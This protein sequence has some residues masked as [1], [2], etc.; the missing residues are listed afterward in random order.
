MF[1]QFKALVW[2]RGWACIRLGIQPGSPFYRPPN[3]EKKKKNQFTHVT[4]ECHK[5]KENCSI[6]KSL[7]SHTGHWCCWHCCCYC[8]LISMSVNQISSTQSTCAPS[9]LIPE[10]SSRQSTITTYSMLWG[11]CCC[12]FFQ[13]S[14]FPIAIKHASNT[15]HPFSD[16]NRNRYPT[17]HTKS[18][19][20]ISIKIT[21]FNRN[22]NN[23]TYNA[24]NKTIPENTHWNT[25]CTHPP[26]TELSFHSAGC[27]IPSHCAINISLSNL[28]SNT[29]AHIHIH[30][31]TPTYPMR[32]NC[33]ICS[34]IDFR[35]VRFVRECVDALLVF[36]LRSD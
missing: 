9:C 8:S 11:C 31:H 18:I 33:R 21:P 20:Y 13:L 17:K 7:L 14:A 25:T 19:R 30:T 5:N 35:T 27:L 29:Q 3:G 34:S 32:K 23:C 6:K 22:N 24:D 28:I 4:N 15:A 10:S 12:C 16:T 2:A 26:A 1:I 36:H